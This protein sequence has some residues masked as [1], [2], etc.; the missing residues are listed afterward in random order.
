M[1]SAKGTNRNQNQNLY[2][3]QHT[4][5][6][7]LLNKLFT[8]NCCPTA[9]CSLLTANCQLPPSHC[10]PFPMNNPRIHQLKT[11][12][13]EDP[14][15]NF[16][17]FALALEYIKTGELAR[18]EKLFNDIL[19]NNP[20]YVGVYYHLGKLYESLDDTGLAKTTYNKGIAVAGKIGDDLAL[21]ELKTALLE[22]GE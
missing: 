18:A 6:C 3:Y 15:D 22:C 9:H 17:L 14:H 2:Q 8:A 21:S 16:T 11:F 7:H 13:Q 5:H 1:K 12:L 10:L 4:T 20:D 19:S